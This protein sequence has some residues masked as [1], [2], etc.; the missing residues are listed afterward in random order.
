MTN[1]YGL[2]V[3]ELVS[4]RQ[5]DKVCVYCAKEM[6]D[7]ISNTSRN[8][9]ATIEHLH[10]LEPWNDSTWIAY[11]CYSCNCSRGDKKLREWFKKQYC[12]ERNINEESVAQIVQDYLATQQ[13][14]L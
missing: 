7:T 12:L 5:R 4:A 11:C 10:R 1:K 6:R 9:W 14:W 3:Q 2:P 8:D 13:S